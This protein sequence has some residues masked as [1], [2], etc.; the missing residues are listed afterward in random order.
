MSTPR[1]ESQELAPRH[2]LPIGHG[3][4]E[5]PGDDGNGVTGGAPGGTD[6]ELRCREARGG[7]CRFFSVLGGRSRC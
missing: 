2:G 5:P 1:P 7:F 6:A 3:T 4:P